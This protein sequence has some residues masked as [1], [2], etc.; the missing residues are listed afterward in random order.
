MRK[1]WLLPQEASLQVSSS[2]WFRSVILSVP[3]QMVDHTM[4]VAWRSWHERNEVTHDKPL[5]STES[6]KKFLCNYVK[7]LSSIK[8]TSIDHMLKGK[9]PMLSAE[10]VC[11]LPRL[12][13]HPP[14]K[15]WVKPPHGWA[16]LSID[17]SFQSENG[18]AGTGM[19]LRDSAGS[20]IFSACRSL[21]SC[22]KPFEAEILACLEGLEFGLLHTQL[23]IMIESDCS[24]LISA[25]YAKDQ[26]RS[27]FL[28]S[29]SEIKV[30]ASGSSVCNFVKVNRSQ[31][32]ISHCLANLA[33]TENITQFRL[34]SSP[35]CVTQALV[36]E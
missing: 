23:P 32:R 9:S 11:H 7:I 26:D 12:E 22:E 2:S 29:I 33:R 21:M 28:H 27:P 19:V 17:G 3:I 31:V 10:V 1:C 20:V 25:I 30:L 14:D 6:S 8:D 18:S 13:K 24:Q 35:E 16:K 15:P 4:L 36:D 5:P 34:G